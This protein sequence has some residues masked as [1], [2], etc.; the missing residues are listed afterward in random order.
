[1]K[2]EEE[3]SI[4]FE[5]Q[6]NTIIESLRLKFAKIILNFTEACNNHHEEPHHGDREHSHPP[7]GGHGHSG[8]RPEHGDHN[9][10]GHHPEQG[11]RGHHGHGNGHFSSDPRHDYNVRIRRARNPNEASN[12]AYYGQPM[13]GMAQNNYMRYSDQSMQDDNEYSQPPEHA[14]PSYPDTYPDYGN[15]APMQ[16]YSHE[17]SY[18]S[19]ETGEYTYRRSEPTPYNNQMHNQHG[20]QRQMNNYE[21]A[22]NDYGASN[23][24][25]DPQV[26]EERRDY[27]N[28]GMDPYA[29]HQ[30]EISRQTRLN[31]ERMRR[32]EEEKA[33]YYRDHSK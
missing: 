21:G 2:D 12:G 6:I 1:M 30:A 18:S 9:N 20:E 31:E 26:P 32:Y 27:Q 28:A 8:H 17:Q 16:V 10:H 3:I 7:G 29:A 11:G 5:I 14:Y 15:R 23:V 4:K 25:V 19:R 24:F 13:T 22:N 33:K